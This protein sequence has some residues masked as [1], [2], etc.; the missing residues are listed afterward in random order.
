MKCR[1]CS[2]PTTF[3]IERNGEQVPLCLDCNLK[4]QALQRQQLEEYERAMNYA[5]GQAEVAMG[6]PGLLPRFPPRE[7]PVALHT[8]DLVTHNLTVSGSSIGVLNSGYIGSVDSAIG[9]L[10]STGEQNVA[11]AL[12]SFTD[13]LLVLE[14][15]RADQKNELLELLSMISAEATVPPK[16]RR[17]LAMRSL[18]AEVCAICSGVASLAALYEQ[19][20]P[21]IAALFS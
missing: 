13:A 9:A 7:R 20:S 4:L 8:G 12:K 1:E 21:A 14:D 16:N 17:K 6:M 10:Y 5:V 18:L 15:V 11:D 3:A 2:K 19:F